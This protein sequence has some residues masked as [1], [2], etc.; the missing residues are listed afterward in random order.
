MYIHMSSIMAIA[1]CHQR[2][3]RPVQ[4]RE[5]SDSSSEQPSLVAKTVVVSK[6]PAEPAGP[7]EL[8]EDDLA[9]TIQNEYDPMVP[10]NYEMI[11]KQKKA[12][13]RS[14]DSDRRRRSEHR[15]EHRSDRRSTRRRS[16]GSS[17][18]SDSEGEERS[19]RRAR[20]KDTA[21][22]PPPSSLSSGST[23]PQEKAESEEKDVVHS[24]L[25]ELSK[26]KAEKTGPFARPKIAAVASNIMS[27]Y[28]WKEGQGLGRQSQGMSTALAVEKTSKRGGKII[29]V[30]AER[31]QQLAEEKKR[32]HS[33]T[34]VMRKP[35]KV[36]LLKNMVGPGEVDE[37]LQPETTE[38]CSKYGEV[39]NCLVYEI[40]HGVDE[41]EAVRIFVQFTRLESAIKAVVDLNGRF[42]GGRTVCATFFS[43]ERFG[44]FDLGPDPSEPLAP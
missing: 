1:F 23:K 33:L 17:S 34:D 42:F 43:E 3:P 22:I 37:D 20:R 14:R 31:E 2:A 12:E 26:K 36:V 13:E 32:A 30:A 9:G 11:M 5:V 27:K 18:G 38:E 8:W 28:G 25:E 29:N 4:P 21:A 35:T 41:K 10:N 6:I 24:A 16:R 40:P 15:S 39:A 19:R 7:T 44:N